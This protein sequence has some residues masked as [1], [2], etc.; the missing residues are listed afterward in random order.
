VESPGAEPAASSVDGNGWGASLLKLPWEVESLVRPGSPVPADPKA[1]SWVSMLSI[2]VLA[3]SAFVLMNNAS[4][5]ELQAMIKESFSSFGLGFS[6]DFLL[7]GAVL[8]VALASL[9]NET[10]LPL[11]ILFSWMML[12]PSLLYYSSIDWFLS[13]GVNL[14]FGDL[15]NSLPGWLIFLNGLLLVT[16]SLLLRSYLQLRDV[17]RNLIERGALREEMDVNLHKDLAFNAAIIGA[18]S[19]GA[20]AIAVLVLVLTPAFSDLSSVSPYLYLGIG[21]VVELIIITFI[22]RFLKYGRILRTPDHAPMK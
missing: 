18:C 21:L 10:R 3:L 2:I 14:S 6:S 19:L 4:F 1:R 9:L 22:V 12:L 13:L 7:V 17:R 20:A 5:I 8:V 11:V 15:G 16:A